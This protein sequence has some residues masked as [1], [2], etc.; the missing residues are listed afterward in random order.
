[1]PKVGFN[2]LAVILIDFVFKK[3]LSAIS[4]KEFEFIVKEK[5]H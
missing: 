2:C 4:L 1:M 3:L 5:N